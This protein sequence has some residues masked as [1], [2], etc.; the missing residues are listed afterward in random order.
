MPILI[1][2]PLIKTTLPLALG[3]FCVLGFAPFYFYP[4]SIL[5]L[6]SL[7]YIW[8][9]CE[10]AKQAAFIGFMYGLAYFWRH[11]GNYGRFM[12]IFT[13]GIPIPVPSLSRRTEQAH[14]KQSETCFF[15]CSAGILG[16]GRLGQ[17]LD[18]YRLSLAHHRLQPDTA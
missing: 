4:I 10:T 8:R 9:G 15:D 13:G 11:A 12:H 16:I 6:I 5:S 14:F 2:T 17:K 18:F 3:A 1:K 7:I